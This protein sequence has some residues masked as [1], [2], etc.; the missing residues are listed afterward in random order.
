M[1]AQL[2]SDRTFQGKSHIRRMAWQF[3]DCWEVV[4]LFKGN[5]QISG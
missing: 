2:I 1:L 3:W 5:S 4:F